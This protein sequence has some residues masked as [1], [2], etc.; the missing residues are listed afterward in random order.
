MLA[1]ASNAGLSVV[2]LREQLG[3]AASPL[4][5]HLHRLV[6]AG[7]IAE[8]RQATTLICRANS[9]TIEALLGYLIDECFADPEP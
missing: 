6:L 1:R 5:D 9:R 2:R 8:E 3:I 4:S 7:L